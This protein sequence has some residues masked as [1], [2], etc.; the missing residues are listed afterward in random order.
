MYQEDVGVVV[1]LQ[2]KHIPNEG[3][4][5]ISI[6]CPLGLDAAGTDDI[7]GVL[8]RDALVVVAEVLDQGIVEVRLDARPDVALQH[9]EEVLLTA[10]A[11][12]HRALAVALAFRLGV[13]IEGDEVSLGIW[14]RE[15]LSDAV[16]LGDL[17]TCRCCNCTGAKRHGCKHPC[18]CFC[19]SHI[20]HRGDI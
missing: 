6:R 8:D 15:H 19:I 5:L 7:A 10:R 2:F 11:N 18:K 17:L 12:L 4:G 20:A 13:R 16:E 3:I 1:G 9:S 14:I